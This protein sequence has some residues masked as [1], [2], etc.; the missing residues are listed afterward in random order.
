MSIDQSASTNGHSNG[1]ESNTEATDTR[2]SAFNFKEGNGDSEVEALDMNFFPP[3]AGDQFPRSRGTKKTHIFGQTEIVRTSQVSNT[4]PPNDINAWYERARR[5]AA[6]LTIS[7]TKSIPLPF[8]LLSS[9]PEIYATASPNTENVNVRTELA[10]TTG[11]SSR[12]KSLQTIVNRAIGV[13]EREALSNSLGEMAEG[14]EEGWSSGSDS[15]D[16]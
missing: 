4:P 1:Q 7:Q 12:L 9:F 6:G 2:I 8:P 5:R 11:I 15:G 10:T 3:D 14:Y 16:D 13:E